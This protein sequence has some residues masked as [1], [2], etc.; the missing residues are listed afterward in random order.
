MLWTHAV[1]GVLDMRVGLDGT[2]NMVGDGLTDKQLGMLN[3]FRYLSRGA[4]DMPS[5]AEAS[6]SG[7]YN[8]S[9]PWTVPA[10]Q[11][12]ATNHSA[13]TSQSLPP[14]LCPR[15]PHGRQHV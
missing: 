13:P 1:L 2:R 10:N 9:A 4:E 15:R 12:R 5:A 3:W 6:T 14:L 11:V 7:V 8:W